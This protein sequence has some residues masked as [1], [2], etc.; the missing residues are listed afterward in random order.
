MNPLLVML[1]LMWRRRKKSNGFE[2]L[3]GKAM[4]SQAGHD[5]TF[6]LG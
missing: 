6:L 5:K 4:Q 3:T 2:F 1:A